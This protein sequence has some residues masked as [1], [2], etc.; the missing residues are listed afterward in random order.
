M[1]CKKLDTVL[2][3]LNCQAVRG[4]YCSRLS[5]P[6]VYTGCLV[7]DLSSLLDRFARN[8]EIALSG[9]AGKLLRVCN[10]NVALGFADTLSPILVL[11]V[12]IL[13][14]ILES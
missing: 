4:V 2:R 10:D 1:A 5:I 13:V 3:A 9:S 12:R 8:L 11:L 7:R 14:G 6:V